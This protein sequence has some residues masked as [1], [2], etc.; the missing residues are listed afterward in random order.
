MNEQKLLIETKVP[1][2]SESLQTLINCNCNSKGDF[3]TAASNEL[4]IISTQ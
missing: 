3:E 1:L 2:Q 4:L